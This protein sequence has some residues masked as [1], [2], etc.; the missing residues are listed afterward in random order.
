MS[1]RL[2]ISSRKTRLSLWANTENKK[3][4]ENIKTTK[5]FSQAF[6]DDTLSVAGNEL[7]LQNVVDTTHKRWAWQGVRIISYAHRKLR[8]ETGYW[9]LVSRYRTVCDYVELQFTAQCASRLS[10]DTGTSWGS[11]TLFEF[12]QGLGVTGRCT[13][14][15]VI[16]AWHC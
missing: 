16:H 6:V 2:L 1:L 13:N 8:H 11:S 3:T 10:T 7:L 9:L 14:L 5:T 15:L 4:V 12:T